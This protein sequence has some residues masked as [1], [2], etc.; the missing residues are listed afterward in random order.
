MSEM[1]ENL[2][3]ELNKFEFRI[4]EDPTVAQVTSR[5]GSGGGGIFSLYLILLLAAA[6]IMVR[7]EG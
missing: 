4:K 2:A 6:G 5:D 7:Q 1:S 3:I